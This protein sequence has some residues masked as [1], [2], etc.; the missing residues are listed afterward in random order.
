MSTPEI[1]R[2]MEAAR[3]AGALSSKICGAGGGGCMVTF[4]AEGAQDRVREAL[5]ANGA[6]P[7]AF[8]I[9]R[10]GLKVR[11]GAA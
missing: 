10:E 1:D 8:R 11:R 6:R 5:V 7:I 4:V 9:S 2:M 3:S